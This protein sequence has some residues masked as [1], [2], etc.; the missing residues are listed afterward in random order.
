MDQLAKRKKKKKK[1]ENEIFT[2][3]DTGT[4]EKSREDW[5]PLVIST[6]KNRERVN[7]AAR[8]GPRT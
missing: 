3:R 5:E 4:V 6:V 7:M 1:K 8:A 2:S